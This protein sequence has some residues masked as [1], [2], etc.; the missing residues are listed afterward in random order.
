VIALFEK[1]PYLMLFAFALL[2]SLHVY[3]VVTI[4]SGDIAVLNIGAENETVWFGLVGNT[5]RAPFTRLDINATPGDISYRT[6]RI[7]DDSCPEN[8]TKFI[9]MIFT[10]SST[11]IVDIFP[12]SLST[13]DRFINRFTQSGTNTFRNRSTFTTR[14]GRMSGV[15]TTYT[16]SPIPGNFPL[17]YFQDQN[18]NLVFITTV[19]L[20]QTGFSGIP[21]DYQVML[22]T[23][24][25]NSTMY[26]FRLDVYC[27][28]PPPSPPKRPTDPINYTKEKNETPETP[29]APNETC[30]SQIYCG[31]FSAC[32][33]GFKTQECVDIS[34]CSDMKSY[35]M[36]ACAEPIIIEPI[37]NVTLPEPVVQSLSVREENPLVFWAVMIAL[38]M[39]GIGILYLL[40]WFIFGRR[41][42]YE[43]IEG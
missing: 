9:N 34:G 24:D 1:T 6:I 21:F 43:D 10:N 11:S 25:G 42:G 22:P 7:G 33:D 20:N 30:V 23:N 26:Y 18:G 5:S 3:A 15:P 16:N 19:M 39:V 28:N 31:D 17:G 36:E 4:H 29:A 13:L 2:L 8:K 40:Y 38:V 27:N 41:R 35:I 12:G 37:T 32:E 14:F